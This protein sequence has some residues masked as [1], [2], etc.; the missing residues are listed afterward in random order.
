M[1]VSIEIHRSLVIDLLA[2]QP[3]GGAQRMKMKLTRLE[4]QKIAETLRSYSLGLNTKATGGGTSS[5]FIGQ[6]V[7]G[8]V[9][10]SSV[11]RLR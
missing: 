6:D 10:I 1:S 9:H 8:P 5:L 7:G 11:V 2:L 3:G 4:A